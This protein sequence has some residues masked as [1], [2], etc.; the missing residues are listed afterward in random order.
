MNISLECLV[1]LQS[2]DAS[3]S[4]LVAAVAVIIAVALFGT[5]IADTTNGRGLRSGRLL[6]RYE[7]SS[8]KVLFAAG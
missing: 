8:V 4:D 3:V 1:L 5:V 6:D 2:G 7:R